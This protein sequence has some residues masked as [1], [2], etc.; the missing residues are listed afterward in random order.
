MAIVGRALGVPTV[1]GAVEL[2][3]TEM[4]GHELII[5]GFSGDVISRATRRMRRAY[6]HRL[7]G[8]E[9]AGQRS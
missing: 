9:A 8:R 3:W 1:M 4:E 6:L 5:D 2:P 7:A